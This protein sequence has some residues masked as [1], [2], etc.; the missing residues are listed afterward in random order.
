MSAVG[1]LADRRQQRKAIRQCVQSKVS[2]SSVFFTIH[3]PPTIESVQLSTPTTYAWHQASRPHRDSLNRENRSTVHDSLFH[4]ASSK[5]RHYQPR[6]SPH[7]LETLAP[8][9]LLSVVAGSSG[10]VCLLYRLGK[11]FSQLSH[12][13]VSNASVH[14]VSYFYKRGWPSILDFPGQLLI[15]G[16]CPGIFRTPH[17]MQLTPLFETLSTICPFFAIILL[18]LQFIS[19][20]WKIWRSCLL[21]L[22]QLKR[23]DEEDLIGESWTNIQ[24]SMGGLKVEIHAPL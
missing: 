15:S 14:Y 10:W 3:R 24:D 21:N 19:R 23:V 22:Y 20:S 6:P 5:S 16:H 17:R 8:Y 9:S 7:K 1:Y 2:T 18:N 13:R 12:Y 4:E 11:M